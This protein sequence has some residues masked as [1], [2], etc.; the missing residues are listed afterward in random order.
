M[1]V[2]EI[3]ILLMLVFFIGSLLR[4][5]P[6]A[7]VLAGTGVI[8]TVLGWMA[9]NYLGTTTG[10]DYQ[11][12]GL[13]VNRIYKI[14]DNW[15]L[16]ALPMFI[17]MG[18]MLEKANIAERLMESLLKIF[19]GIHGGLAIA[20]MVIGIMLAASIG[21]IGASITLLGLLALPTMQRHGYAPSLA[22]GTVASAG[23]LGILIPPSI[24]LVIMADQLS[25]S[26]GDLFMGAVMPGLLLGGLYICYILVLGLI[27]PS[28]APVNKEP[29]EF[30]A[31]D[32]IDLAKNMLP[33]LLLIVSVLG[34]I[35]L[36]LATPTE[37]SGVGALGSL[38]LAVLYKKFSMPVLFEVVKKTLDTTGYIFMIF[39]GA[40]CFALVLRMLGGDEFIESAMLSAPF[41]PSGVLVC[42]LL[43]VFLLGFILDWI[44]ITL[45]VLP[46]LAPIISL[47]D[48]GISGFGA[49]GNPTI[50]WFVM[51]VAL[52]LQT[53]FLTPPVGF[54]LFFL[55]GVCPP[56]IALK[57]IYKSVFPFVII[58]LVAIYLVY[59]NPEITLWLPNLMYG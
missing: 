54:A 36:G 34:S 22:L 58:Q 49:V 25:L 20:V 29:A 44:E 43:L 11:V 17:F 30:K 1:L 37:A 4:G 27:K 13:L 6:V 47:L 45:I 5:I 26:V 42:I 56:D 16:V 53:S 19:G 55:K 18:L 57:D 52:T 23:C 59:K 14:M 12:L 24:M 50:I 38:A 32:I 39:I 21:I 9:D 46:L 15:V 41:G 31:R 48:F 33:V 40:T 28:D 2:N 51:L 10:L 8:F 35:F 3:L 7:Y